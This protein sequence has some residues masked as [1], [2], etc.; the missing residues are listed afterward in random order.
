MT[1][2]PSDEDHDVGIG[3]ELARHRPVPSP[4][5]RGELARYLATEDPG[6]GPRPRRL[7][8]AVFIYALA[9]LVLMLVGLLIAGGT[10]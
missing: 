6:Y 2:H 9:G 4:F 7:W 3:E 8:T 5:F 10:I 1:E